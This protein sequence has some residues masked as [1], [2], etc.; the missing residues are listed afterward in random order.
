MRPVGP[1]RKAA[2]GTSSSAAPISV[3]CRF[4]EL[5][6]EAEPALEGLHQRG[7]EALLFPDEGPL[8]IGAH[9]GEQRGAVADERAHLIFFGERE[10]RQEAAGDGSR[11]AVGQRGEVAGA[12]HDV[13]L[14]RIGTRRVVGG[15][16]RG[17]GP[18]PTLPG[19]GD[20]GGHLRAVKEL[21][22]VG[23]AF[24]VDEEGAGL[25]GAEQRRKLGHHLVQRPRADGRAVEQRPQVPRERMLC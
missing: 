6:L 18:Q 25:L 12:K 23:G 21:E 8:A 10:A 4:V 16:V 19:G 13:A 9:P 24:A 14:A 7:E 20:P 2:A 22:V 15:K 5:A 17:R 11:P 1:S 3:A